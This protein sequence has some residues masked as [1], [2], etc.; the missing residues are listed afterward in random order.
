M[1]EP[2]R[3]FG[4]CGR[5]LNT[6]L[7][8][9][10][11]GGLPL[12]HPAQTLG[13]GDLRAAAGFSANVATGPLA[14]SLAA[15]DHSSLPV[16]GPDAKAALVAASIAPSLAPW[17]GA[18]VGISHRAEGGLTYTGRAARAD[19]RRSFSLSRNWALSIGAGGSAVLDSRQTTETL[20]DFRLGPV[21]GWGADA[22][23]L[24]GY[25]SDGDLYMIWLGA[26]GGWEQVDATAQ[27]TV[28]PPFL[29]TTPPYRVSA[30]R[31]WGGG[32]LGAAVGFRHVHV[33]M[34]IDVSYGSVTGN[35]GAVH[36]QVAGL[37]LTPASCLWWDF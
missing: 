10:C 4:A 2:D 27:L 21:S 35:V 28:Q 36:A 22:P 7:L 32:L 33:A 16:L 30:T 17:V 18:R 8:A 15:A 11:G 29:V 5:F 23:L 25:A 26:R 3:R 9:G 6:L 37:V 1:S 20:S 12:L 14:D 13:P 24:V 31:F 34:E 19:V